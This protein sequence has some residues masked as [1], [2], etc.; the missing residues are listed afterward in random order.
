MQ[1]GIIS[2]SYYSRSRKMKL[3]DVTTQKKVQGTMSPVLPSLDWTES[4]ITAVTLIHR[5][6]HS[7]LHSSY[8]LTVLSAYSV[9]RKHLTSC[10][11]S[12]SLNN[13]L[14]IEPISQ[15]S[16]SNS[17]PNLQPSLQPSSLVYPALNQP[18]Y[19]THINSCSFHLHILS[20]ST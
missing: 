13:S 14:P 12:G 4:I 10:P 17:Q 16:S 8:S 15:S 18:D 7:G 19:P 3:G 6:T 11:H 9:K 20:I 2:S 1:S 5:C